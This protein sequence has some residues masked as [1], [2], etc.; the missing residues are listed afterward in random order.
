MTVSC[1]AGSVEM[2]AQE[3]CQPS[4]LSAS[5]PEHTNIYTQH[6]F[7]PSPAECEPLTAGALC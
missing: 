1:T 4:S 5:L 2:W 3:M 6:H 7:N